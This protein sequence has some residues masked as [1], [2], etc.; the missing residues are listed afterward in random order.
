MLGPPDAVHSPE[1]ILRQH[2]G[3]VVLFDPSRDAAVLR[4]PGLRVRSLVFGPIKPGES[5]IVAGYSK[6]E[7]L[8]V[9]SGNVSRGTIAYGPDVY[10]KRQIRREVHI[11]HAPVKTGVPGGPL[12]RPDGTVSGMVF[13]SDIRKPSGYALAAAEIIRSAMD[14]TAATATVST[15]GCI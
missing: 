6:G 8:T 7:D 9:T 10:H 5:A 13:A 12:L 2:Q 11:V 1:G 3:R 15:Q 14:G 4:V